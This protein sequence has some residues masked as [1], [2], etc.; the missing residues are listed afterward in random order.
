[1][2]HGST[3]FFLRLVEML[4]LA[5]LSLGAV[6]A[7]RLSQGPLDLG[8]LTPTVQEMVNRTLA[9]QGQQ[10]AV[11]GADVVW[12]TGERNLLLRFRDVSL[13]GSDAVVMARLPEVRVVL[14]R[15]ALLSFQLKPYALD[16]RQPQV[17]VQRDRDGA[18][19]LG[20]KAIPDTASPSPLGPET[21]DRGGQVITT[22]VAELLN[23]QASRLSEV[24]I[25][26]A[27]LRFNDSISGAVWQMSD[28]SLAVSRQGSGQIGFN[29]SASGASLKE[30][31][32]P[33][34]VAG[35]ITFKGM[36]DPSSRVLGW[37]GSV[38]EGHPSAFAVYDA[39][40]AGITQE[41]AATASGEVLIGMSQ[42][43]Q[44]S[45]PN[46]SNRWLRFAV[47]GGAGQWHVPAPFDR[48]LGVEAVSLNGSLGSDL[49]T[50]VIERAEVDLAPDL[51]E[52]PNGGNA[53]NKPNGGNAVSKPNGP[54]A[55][56][57]SVRMAASGSLHRHPDRGVEGQLAVTVDRLPGDSL[58]G[59]W[60]MG[61]A[62]GARRWVLDN[63][64]GGVVTH[65][66]WQIG[67][68]GPAVTAL[69]LTSLTGVAHGEHWDVHYFRPL[70]V[71]KDVTGDFVFGPDS[72]TISAS[73]TTVQNLTSSLAEMVITHLTEPVPQAT[74][75]VVAAGPIPDA[76]AMLDEKPFRFL[77]RFGLKP[78]QGS[79]QVETSIDLAFPL[80]EILPLEQVRVKVSAKYSD[81][82]FQRVAFGHDLTHTNGRVIVDNSHLEAD[83]DGLIA[84]V[85][86]HFA[87]QENF[88][89][90]PFRS[91]Y[92]LQGVLPED[93]RATFGLTTAPLTPDI[94]A[95]SVPISLDITSFTS[96]AGV[97]VG[98]ADLSQSVMNLAPWGWNKPAGKP[99][100]LTATL[101]FNRGQLMDI[102]RFQ[103]VADGSETL[104]LEG[105]ASFD[106]AGEVSRLDLT[107]LKIGITNAVV[108]ATHGKGKQPWRVTATG[109]GLD[110]RGFMRRLNE[111][112]PL[113]DHAA[114]A[115]VSTAPP[116]LILDA[117]FDSV[118]LA[119]EGVFERVNAALTREA[120]QWRSVSL[121]AEVR[122]GLPLTASLD[123]ETV[124]HRRV[125]VA[126]DN[127]GAFLHALGI[128][129][130]LH[131][132][133][134]FLDGQVDGAGEA[135]GTV[136]IRDYRLIKAPLL[137]RILS[138]AALT[139]VL[140]ALSGEGIGFKQLT[141]PFRAKEGVIT[142]KDGRTSGSALGFTAE[143][144]IDLAHSTLALTGT[145][146]PAFAVNGL[147]GDIPLLGRLLT[148]NEKGGGLFAVD[149]AVRGPTANPA[150]S[151]NP[152]STLTPGFLRSI[153]D[154]FN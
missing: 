139:G 150:I 97:L 109:S 33:A 124:E 24:R 107:T 122:D 83:G 123:G 16:F 87:W 128:A 77:S 1:M 13:Q 129:T 137:A 42:P 148:N 36:F 130:T 75:R 29:G 112:M 78:E 153:F 22:M 73:P 49:D 17:I 154:V 6:A 63:T 55:V 41:V 131:G 126:S 56:G 84:G 144:T 108:H 82:G 90:K 34:V 95:G 7:L 98:S 53:V 132:G 64:G 47:T 18:L 48:P 35:T 40:L 145:I 30:A 119:D 111:P 12:E 61:V 14:D 74:V 67:F 136:I 26:D 27:A 8:Q 80:L 93:Q 113:A 3:R 110:G 25:S 65:A 10:L 147:V 60:P 121:S 76:L 39:R 21:P 106:D 152:L 45:Q 127:A 103:V 4:C 62:D 9:S 46:L 146:V 100:T 102:S 135:V 11:G 15:V 37:S 31:E 99:A 141:A 140:D 70:P 51:A 91:H 118:R 92:A 38:T 2:I 28:L 20:I 68:S 149:Y 54:P 50:L 58:R 114:G 138:V 142:L 19:H 69:T 86:T 59:W 89:G 143:G 134:L 32:T 52:T 43:N 105:K 88:N 79:G 44:P 133:T 5:V 81:A 116:D 96:G 57:K 101:H 120:G 94:I 66:T 115:A 85:A 125:Q 104:G 72:L 151:V 117:H 71:A 23:P